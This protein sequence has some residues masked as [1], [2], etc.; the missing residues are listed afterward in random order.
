MTF[1]VRGN[2]GREAVRRGY[3]KTQNSDRHV[4]SQCFN[5]NLH[6]RVYSTRLT[7]GAHPRVQPQMSLQRREH[8]FWEKGNSIGMRVLSHVAHTRFVLR[9]SSARTSLL[10]RRGWMFAKGP[11]YQLYLKPKLF[12]CEFES[13]LI[14]CVNEV[15]QPA[16]S[17]I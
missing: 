13:Y 11:E 5:K 9:A 1:T 8:V 17:R 3:T 15:F 10:G 14:R 6:L 4:H 7:R 16:W 12:Y 2:T